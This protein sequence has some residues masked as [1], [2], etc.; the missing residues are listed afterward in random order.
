METN[1]A[2]TA[3]GFVS[4]F[5]SGLVGLLIK[6]LGDNQLELVKDGLK[7]DAD[8]SLERIKNDLKLDSDRRLAE[9][10][11]ELDRKLAESKTQYDWVYQRAA[12]AATDL[13]AR[14]VKLEEACREQTHL[15]AHG[16]DS[17]AASAGESRLE[18]ALREFHDLFLS[19][20]IN[21][22]E[23][24]LERIQTIDREFGGP[25]DPK[26]IDHTKIAGEIRALRG[27]LQTLLGGPLSRPNR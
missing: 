9:F 1:A 27:A 16:S 3:S 18:V 26:P 2:L 5:I 22:D 8:T 6:S 23:R 21:F 7:R 24:I 20:A 14:L 13:Y 12:Q 11:N 19:A 17:A 10:K 25:G 15:I 4:L